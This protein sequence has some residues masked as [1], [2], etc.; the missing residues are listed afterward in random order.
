MSSPDCGAR[1][2]A[3]QDPMVCESIVR[4]SSIPHGTA[5]LAQG[6][7]KIIGL[8]FVVPAIDITPFEIGNPAAKVPLDDTD[9]SK[10]SNSR[11][12]AQ[13]GSV[14]Q[15]MVDDPA[16]V[17]RQALDGTT[18]TQVVEIIVSSSDG[19]PVPGGGTRNVA[20]LGNSQPA[21]AQASK[22]DSTFWIVTGRAQSGQTDMLILYAQTVLLDFGGLSWPHVTVGALRKNSS[23][24]ATD[25]PAPSATD[26]ASSTGNVAPVTQP[27]VATP[28][29]GTASGAS[30]ATAQSPTGGQSSS[31]VDSG[32]WN[33]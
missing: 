23:G 10:P 7:A 31:P 18:I 13:P 32:Q 22:V 24:A 28:P 15:G 14:T 29:G 3:T 9:L 6:T 8:P 4:M 33:G 5:L 2:P 17:L 30:S 11:T 27:S 21:N 26:P 16:N 12:D 1:S 25:N 19:A 20:F